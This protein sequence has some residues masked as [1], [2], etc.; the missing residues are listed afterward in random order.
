MPLED[1]NGGPLVFELPVTY[2]IDSGQWVLY[3]PYICLCTNCNNSYTTKWLNSFIYKNTITFIFYQ[4]LQ[5]LRFFGLPPR[6]P[7]PPPGRSLDNLDRSF[8]AGEDHRTSTLKTIEQYLS[9]M[10]GVVGN[11]HAC[12]LRAICEVIQTFIHK[13]EKRS[14]NVV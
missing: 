12:V 9:G 2:D 6:P 3:I 4:L 11:G 5:L 1:G 8:K 13:Y 10:G 14:I 7:G